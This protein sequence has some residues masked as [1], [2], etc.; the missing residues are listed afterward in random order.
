[1]RKIALLSM[2]LS[3]AA[4]LMAADLVPLNV[5]TGLWQCTMTSSING[6][7][8]NTSNYT[9]CVKA[10]DLGSYPFTDPKA[11][12][13]WTVQN[14]TGTVMDATGTCMPQGMGKVSFTMH[15]VATDTQD[16]KGTGQ[17]TINLPNGATMN[18]NYSGS[19]KWASATCPAK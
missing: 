5:T 9:S 16:V 15:L 19:G 7:P 10:S 8:S 17:M 11:N 13:T 14:S 2:I 12:C 4:I 1:M 18:G 6:G 3:S